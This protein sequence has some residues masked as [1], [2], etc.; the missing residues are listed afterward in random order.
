MRA[1]LKA[2]F[3]VSSRR[4]YL[5]LTSCIA[6]SS[7][8]WMSPRPW[9]E[10]RHRRTNKKYLSLKA[11]QNNSKNSYLAVTCIKYHKEYDSV[12][13]WFRDI[14]IS[15][16]HY[17]CPVLT[18]NSN[19]FAWYPLFAG[20]AFVNSIIWM[21]TL[22]CLSPQQEGSLLS[23]KCFQPPVEKWLKRLSPSD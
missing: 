1:F 18:W 7:W 5:S 13:W 20:N 23:S 16:F 2:C 8:G 14:C 3:S 21:S 15:N 6:L 4:M 17:F 22:L 12:D 11:K 10:S 9:K 19:V